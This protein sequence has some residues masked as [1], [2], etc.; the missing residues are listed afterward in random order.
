MTFK[1][2]LKTTLALLI[3]I[4]PTL[5]QAE[6]VWIDVRSPT[7]Y[8]IDH[9]KGDRLIP[10]SEILKEVSELFPNHETEIHLYCRSGNRAGIAKSVLNKA[11]Y[12]NIFNEGSIEDARKIRGL[13]KE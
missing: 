9:I 13:L 2:I 3:F 8:K 12:K 11:G 4:C 10:H 1:K 7:E 5:V 6:A